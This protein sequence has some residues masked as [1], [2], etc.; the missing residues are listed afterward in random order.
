MTYRTE[1][2]LKTN[3]DLSF[4]EAVF[5]FVFSDGDPNFDLPERRRIAIAQL[6]RKNFIPLSGN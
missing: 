6:A 2:P 3:T 5:S 1:Q 4:F